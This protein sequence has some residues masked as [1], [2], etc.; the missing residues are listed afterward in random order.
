MMKVSHGKASTLCI[1]LA[2]SAFN[3]SNTTTGSLGVIGPA[4]TIRPCLKP[5]T[6]DEHGALDLSRAGTYKQYLFP[7]KARRCSSIDLDGFSSPKT[8]SNSEL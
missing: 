5:S 2:L 6:V 8:E 4:T 7:R 1:S 3:E